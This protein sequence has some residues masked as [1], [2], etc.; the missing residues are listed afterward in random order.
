[1]I[2]Y[3]LKKSQ[4]GYREKKNQ[5]IFLRLRGL[6]TGHKI[7]MQASCQEVCVLEGTISQNLTLPSED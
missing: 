6:P 5:T 2:Q 1:M 7:A 4:N 3:R